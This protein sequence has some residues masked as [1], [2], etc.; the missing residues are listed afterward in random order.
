MTSENKTS[1]SSL[2]ETILSD[3]RYPVIIRSVVS[4][5]LFPLFLPVIYQ[6]LSEGISQG[7]GH[8]MYKLEQMNAYVT[9]ILLLLTTTQAFSCAQLSLSLS[10]YVSLSGSLRALS[11]GTSG[12]SQSC[13]RCFVRVRWKLSSTHAGVAKTLWRGLCLF[14]F[15]HL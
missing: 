13:Q 6:N 3:F 4:L 8:D 11:S 14:Y 7:I 12:F 1:N 5:F 10:L 9:L 15:I 2:N